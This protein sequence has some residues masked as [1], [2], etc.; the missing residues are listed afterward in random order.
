MRLGVNG[1][2]CGLEDEHAL[3]IVYLQNV[4][5]F[6]KIIHC[7]HSLRN[8]QQCKLGNKS[9]GSEFIFVSNA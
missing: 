2:I 3:E 7:E 5:Y 8:L 6:D 9:D 1:L 4:N